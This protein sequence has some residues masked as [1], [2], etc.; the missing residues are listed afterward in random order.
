MMMVATYFRQPL[1]QMALIYIAIIVCLYLLSLTSRL[2]GVS[3]LTYG[4]CSFIMQF[5]VYLGPIAFAKNNYDQTLT[6]LIPAKGQEKA[7]LYLIWS[8]IIIPILVWG[9]W[10]T[11]TAIASIFT[12]NANIAG[13]SINL[14]SELLEGRNYLIYLS[15]LNDLIPLSTVVLV[16]AYSRRSRITNGVVAAI[17]SLLTIGI[18][19]ATA[20]VVAA[21]TKL[22]PTLEE[23]ACSPEDAMEMTQQLTS[24]FTDMLTP[25]FIGLIIFSILYTIAIAVLT[26]RKITNRQV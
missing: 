7:T 13:E 19:S 22:A 6:T 24:E 15:K 20:G 11:A 12:A 16:V 3:I 4:V 25:Y 8:Y 2:W 23:M 26:W 17:A 5:M 18:C 1:M 9:T 21:L 14:S 10:W